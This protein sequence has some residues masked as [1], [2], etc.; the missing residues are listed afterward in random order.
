MQHIFTIT[1]DKFR[2]LPLLLTYKSDREFVILRRSN[3]FADIAQ[4]SSK[5]QNIKILTVRYD[6][7][8]L[9]YEVK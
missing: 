5:Y 2:L 6:S 9:Q 4:W 1:E 7:L 3:D 8:N